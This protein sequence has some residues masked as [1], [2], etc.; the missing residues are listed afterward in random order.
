MRN[1]AD[2]GA[3]VLKVQSGT[4]VR[5]RDVAEVTQ[6][7][8]I[9]LGQIG[10]T[11]RSRDGR[12]LDDD[13][14]VHGI[15]LMRKGAEPQA[16]L[17]GIHEKV[18]ELN[19]HLL[20]PGVKIVPHIDRTDLVDYTTHTALHNLGEGIL[21]VVAVLFIFL[22]NARS[23]LIVASTIP[24]SLLFAA[25]LLDL[26]HIPANLLS[27]GALDFG[28]VV[29]GSVVMVENILRSLTRKSGEDIPFT[30]KIARAAHEVQRPV[31][32]AIVIIITA[33][34]PIFTLQRVEGRLFKPMAWTVAFALLGALVFALLMAPVL[35]SFL[36]RKKMREWHNPI[37]TFL[38]G[39]Y[40]RQ[41][42]WC[43]RH[44]WIT[45]LT[46]LVLLAATFYP[47]ISGAIGSEFL[48]HLDEGAIWA[49]GT[50]ASSTGPTEAEQIARKSRQI[51][52]SFPRSPRWCP[53]MEGRMTAPIQPAS[54]TRSISWISSRAR[55]GAAGFARR[56][57]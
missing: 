6:A 34:L 17:Q 38:T 9:R 18:Q 8:K 33:Y 5:V 2:I 35:S 16:T 46:C 20:P 44:R 50:L 30:E 14:V 22:G 42:Y 47:A 10:R 4:P 19:E 29:E 23:A 11:Y 31:F 15:V 48:P 26:R 55:N 36:F 45:V 56:M 24:F 37:L 27:L 39:A 40:R 13:D 57:S 53:S 49:R 1:V 28:M 21:L 52:V 51:L 7:S 32:Y 3:T 41:L 54:S 25:I 12:V 43:I